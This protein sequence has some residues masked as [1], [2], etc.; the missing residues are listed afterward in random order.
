MS[1]FGQVLR[2]KDLGKILLW[3]SFL[4]EKVVVCG[5]CLVTLPLAINETLKWLS[6]VPIRSHCGGDGVVILNRYPL[7]VI[8]VVMV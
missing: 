6:S 8:V 4:L 5:H 2:E 7:G 1:W 3:L